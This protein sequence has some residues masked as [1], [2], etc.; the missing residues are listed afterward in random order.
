MALRRHD[1]F[2]DSLQELLTNLI[3]QS[4]LHGSGKLAIFDGN[5]FPIGTIRFVTS[6]FCSPRTEITIIIH[7][8]GAIREDLERAVAVAG[9]SAGLEV[10]GP[11]ST[12]G[13]AALRAS[14]N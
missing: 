7:I 4:S 14:S 5:D 2:R 3:E 9:A 12:V 8:A 11:G 13:A 1:T 6:D 10:V